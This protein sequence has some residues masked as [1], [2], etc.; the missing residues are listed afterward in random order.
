MDYFLRNLVRRERE[1][2]S[3]VQYQ[4]TFF[5]SLEWCSVNNQKVFFFA[6]LLLPLIGMQNPSPSVVTL[7][8]QADLQELLCRCCL[9]QSQID[10]IHEKFW[11]RIECCLSLR[12]QILISTPLF[13][14]QATGR[15]FQHGSNFCVSLDPSFWLWWSVTSW[16]SVFTTSSLHRIVLHVSSVMKYCP[17]STTLINPAS[18]HIFLTLSVCERLLIRS[19]YRCNRRFLYAG[20]SFSKG[21]SVL[22]SLRTIDCPIT[23]SGC[24]WSIVERI[25]I[26]HTCLRL[27]RKDWADL[28]KQ[29]SEK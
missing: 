12:D 26:L 5:L 10:L 23:I 21:T 22:I 6:V 25:R 11:P 8:L 17:I 27:L 9:N 3:L 13:A 15:N 28:Q 19:S 1:S 4:S 18:M 24:P 7:V 16:K 14:I 2:N 29:L 20:S